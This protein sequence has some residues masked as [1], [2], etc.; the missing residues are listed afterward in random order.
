MQEP[1]ERSRRM[2]SGLMR[3]NGPLVTERHGDVSQKPRMFRSPD[4]TQPKSLSKLG[5]RHAR[6]VVQL[7]RQGERRGVKGP[8]SRRRG[9][10]VIRTD[11]ETVIA[12]EDTIAQS[13]A[14]FI[15]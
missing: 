6:A 11:V 5:F 15:R 3:G 13:A 9:R 14:Q 10:D 4:G 2:P 12:A 1:S 8:F 7:G